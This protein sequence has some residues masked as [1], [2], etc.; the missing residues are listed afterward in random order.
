MFLSVFACC[1]V[2]KDVNLIIM[3][4]WNFGNILTGPSKIFTI[5]INLA[6]FRRGYAS[7]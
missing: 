3:I 5:H 7:A 1:K 4:L 2:K 6:F